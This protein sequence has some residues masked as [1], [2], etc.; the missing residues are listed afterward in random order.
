M[1]LPRVYGLYPGG[2]WR[3]IKAL[4]QAG[5]TDIDK[6]MSSGLYLYCTEL[7]GVCIRSHSV[8][9][10]SGIK[11]SK[12]LHS[13]SS[14]S[15]RMPLPH[16]FTYL[17]TISRGTKSYV[18]NLTTR[19]ASSCMHSKKMYSHL[20]RAMWDYT[21]WSIA[22][23]ISLIS[24][25]LTQWNCKSRPISCNGSA[26]NLKLSVLGQFRSDTVQCQSFSLSALNR[27]RNIF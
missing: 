27:A 16:N 2:P 5:R 13:C 10:L 8:R 17:N 3:G 9:S 26:L 21:F 1:P 24:T 15:L 19:W 14:L 25:N 6:D 22:E 18:S 20:S 12:V 23:S 11:I 4:P 7:C